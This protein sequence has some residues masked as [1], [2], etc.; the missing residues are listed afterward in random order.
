VAVGYATTFGNGDW[1]GVVGKGGVD[2]IIVKYDNNGNV[3]WRKNF[4][5]NAEDRYNSVTAVSDGI[6]AVGYSN[7][8]SF[9][10][11]DW[12]GVAGKGGSSNAIIVKYDHNGNVVWKKNF[13]GSGYSGV[14]SDEY[15]SV[16]VVSNGTVAVG[17]S[18]SLGTGDW[19]SVLGKGGYDAIIVK[20]DNNGNV[21]WKKNFGGSDRDGNGDWAGVQGKG[22]IFAAGYSLESVGMQQLRQYATTLCAS[23]FLCRPE[24][25]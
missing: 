16:I 7:S 2:A 22:S 6:V 5:G 11:G 9:G 20:Y 15:S 13:G 3:V 8:S 25:G 23:K 10:N 19:A 4:G 17:S 24:I 21:V 18:S 1:A 12:A 14:G